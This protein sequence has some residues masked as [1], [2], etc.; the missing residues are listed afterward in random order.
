EG[1]FQLNNVAAGRYRVTVLAPGYI[2][3]GTPTVQLTNGQALSNVD[4]SLTKGGVIT[5]KVAVDNNRAVISEPI[6]LTPL[7]ETGQPA[8]QP[9]TLPANFRT[10]DR[11][12]YRV[13]GVPAGR[14]LLSVGRGNGPG[15][16]GGFGGGGRVGSGGAQTWQRTYYPEALDVTQATPIEVAAGSEVTGIDIHLM[17][18]ATYAI[19]GRV[20]DQEGNPVAGVLIGDGSTS[21]RGNG[22]NG[23]N[24][25][26]RATGGNGNNGGSAGNQPNRPNQNNGNT[27]TVVTSDSTDGTTD[28][29]GEF[30][31]EGVL[32]GSYAVYIAQDQDNPADFYSDPVSVAVSSADAAGVEVKLQRAAS[33]S[34][35]VVIEGANDPNTQAKLANLNVSA[36]ARGGGSSTGV[37]RA[38]NANSPVAP[39]GMFRVTGL[40]PGMV[41]L[42]VSDQNA[43]GPFSGLTLL[44]IER[45]GTDA[46]NG[47][48]VGA[49]EQIAGVRVVIAYGSSTV[50]GVV[51]V[52]GGALTPGVR[53]LASARRI[54]NSGGG[55]RGG[56]GGFGGGGALPAQ[57]D[58][59]GRFQIE[60]LV[61]GTY[62]ISV[63]L[64]GGGGGPGGGGAGG[65]G[66]GMATQTVTVGGNNDVQQIVI[67]LSL[68]TL[69]QMQQQLQQQQQGGPRNRNPNQNP[70]QNPPTRPGRRGGLL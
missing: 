49:G 3:A 9:L 57:V 69:Q 39:N 13:Y 38:T 59:N 50:R 30:R 17:T 34:G 14:Y 51:Q 15:G 45:D 40:S 20:I 70:N 8:R 19:T 46:R 66:G 11:G 63:Q 16:P 25:P 24:G 27:R 29:K 47:L 6:T 7:D 62:E 2:V 54:D 35:V 37:V 10:D 56:G 67:P 23:G 68:A 18:R 28:A 31:I 26:N 1:R 5:G 21:N 42:S 32:P 64:I 36:S 12:V 4:F 52:D 61:A 58:A 33:L 22:A 60:R 41:N 43:P 65:R 48:R 55:G 53:L 44:R